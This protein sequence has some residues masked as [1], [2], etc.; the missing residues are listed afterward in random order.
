MSAVHPY[1]DPQGPSGE[2]SLSV[3][4]EAAPDIYESGSCGQ[5]TRGRGQMLTDHAIEF[6]AILEQVGAAGFV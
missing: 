5:S 6:D 4:S 1:C 3:E 2:R